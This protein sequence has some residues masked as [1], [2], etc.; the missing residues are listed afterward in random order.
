[1]AITLSE[2]IHS[3]Y[4]SILRWRAE[5]QQHKLAYVYLEK[6]EQES[7]RL[8]YASL[9][10][11]VRSIS[12]YLQQQNAEKQRVLVLFESELSYACGF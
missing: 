8:T 10:Q 4:I 5:H 3:S 11:K 12:T 6:G 7:E 2:T 9:D 1:M